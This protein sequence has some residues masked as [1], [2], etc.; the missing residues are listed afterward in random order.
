MFARQ[1]ENEK[2]VKTLEK[3]SQTVIVIYG[4]AGVAGCVAALFIVPQ[5]FHRMVFTGG[6]LFFASYI[7]CKRYSRQSIVKQLDA[8]IVTLALTT[9]GTLANLP[10]EINNSKFPEKSILAVKNALPSMKNIRIATNTGYMHP[11]VWVFDTCDFIL[12]GRKGEHDYAI[13]R[14]AKEGKKSFYFPYSKINDAISQA[15]KD[16][17]TLVVFYETKRKERFRSEK[18][19]PDK[20][21]ELPEFTGDIYFLHNSK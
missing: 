10:S 11:M 6:I 20:S 18:Y 21:I 3:L 1:T 2:S 16:K 19:T 9:A 8:L 15:E 4:I 13:D 5:V 7:I 17:K 12:I 14:Y